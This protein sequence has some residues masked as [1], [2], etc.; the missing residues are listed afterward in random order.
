MFRTRATA[1]ECDKH[2]AESKNGLAE[3]GTNPATAH[4]EPR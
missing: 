2:A 4:D 1:H 3:N